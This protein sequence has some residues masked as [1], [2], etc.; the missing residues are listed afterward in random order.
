MK[1]LFIGDIVGKPGRQTVARMIPRLVA[2]LGVDLCVANCENAASGFG[3]TPKLHQELKAMEISVLTSGNHIWSKKEI[4][5]LLDSEA[6]L[7]RPANYPDGVPGHGSCIVSTAGGEQVAF[8]N[9]MGRVFLYDLECP[10]RTAEAEV[11]KLR[12]ETPAIVVDF[13]AEATSEKIAMGWFLDGKVSAVLGTHTHVQTADDTI[14]PGGTAYLTDVGMTGPSNSVIGVK[15]EIIIDKYLH[16]IPRRF[17]TAKGPCRL[18]GVLL[19][20]DGKTGRANEI[21]RLQLE[22]EP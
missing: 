10:F 7:L 2:R 19:D 20:I 8:L 13:H 5:P 14:L 9:L 11:A 1:I 17:D 18:N 4:Y 16:Q 12:E 22:E 6:S 15:K 21:R 3:L